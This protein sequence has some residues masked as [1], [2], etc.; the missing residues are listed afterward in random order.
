[1]DPSK[2]G[3]PGFGP[4]NP[5]GKPTEKAKQTESK[6]GKKAAVPSSN[7]WGGLF[8]LAPNKLVGKLSS[9]LE[10]SLSD[11]QVE[12]LITEYKVPPDSKQA[13]AFCTYSCLKQLLGKK[14]NLSAEDEKA[15]FDAIQEEYEKNASKE[16][17]DP[18][19][20][21]KRKRERRKKSKP[22]V[23]AIMMLI[24]ESVEKL[25]SERGLSLSS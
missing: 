11:P 22:N 16:P 23:N 15:V 12:K 6:E 20:K 10:K 21:R 13:L 8:E 3:L 24:E 18:N 4:L 17:V 14:F 25:E 19:E 7:N 2:L 9:L 5:L 1:M